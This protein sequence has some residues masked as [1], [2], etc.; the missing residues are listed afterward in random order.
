MNLRNARHGRPEKLYRAVAAMAFSC[1][2][3]GS[4]V[5]AQATTGPMP[6]GDSRFANMPT[7]E[8]ADLPTAVD[9]SGRS[10]D[11]TKRPTTVR[12]AG[13]RLVYRIN[14]S[15]GLVVDERRVDFG[16]IT[17]FNADE[18]SRTF[19]QSPYV[20][21]TS[22]QFSGW[23]VAA[24][25]ARPSALTR[26]STPAQIRLARGLQVGVRFYA[27]GSV[28]TRTPVD[29][30]RAGTF[31]ASRRA[32]FAGRTFYFMSSG[33]LAGR[34]LST[35]RATFQR[36][37]PTTS[38]PETEPSPAPAAT[39][40]ALVLVYRE[41]DLTFER[42][43]GTNYHLQARMDGSMHNLVLD[44]LGRFRRS[45]S[46]W[47]SGLA[48]MEM[49]VVE[50]PHPLRS[51][52]EFG[53]GYWVGPRSIASDIDEYVPPG[54]YDSVFVIWQAKD[55]AGEMVPVG[56]W[57]LSLPPGSWANGAGYSSIITPTWEWWWT[58]S[59]ARKRCSC[60]S[61]CTRSSTSTRTP[62]E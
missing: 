32:I 23:W 3:V 19:G 38:I 10:V 44:T 13:T 61:G 49:D 59:S 57:G 14:T 12:L 11:Y 31:L 43:D 40:K 1:V 54:K 51:L 9:V 18:R 8:A 55:D 36:V 53:A 27:D 58:N 33:P 30:A 15:S 24:K 2:L 17:T 60:T 21:L 28:R 52:D 6:G 56:G 35:R 29:L 26:F 5:S 34:W 42:A 16:S 4:A 41:T 37:P 48:A 50:V 39:W 25:S 45:V 62:V 46:G 47:S 7:P 20:R 22:G